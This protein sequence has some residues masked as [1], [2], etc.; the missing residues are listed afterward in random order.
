MDRL[1][2]V[3]CALSLPLIHLRDPPLGRAYIPFSNRRR[4]FVAQATFPRFFE[5]DTKDAGPPTA[6]PDAAKHS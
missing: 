4:R 2:S 5:D 3:A 6:R 1:K